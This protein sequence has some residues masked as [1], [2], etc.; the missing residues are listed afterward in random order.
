MARNELWAQK[1]LVDSA[2]EYNG[3]GEKLSHR[4]KVG[5]P[6][7]LIKLQGRH[8]FIVEAKMREAPVRYLGMEWDSWNEVTVLQRKNLQSWWDAGLQSGVV[9][10]CRLPKNELLVNFY[11]WPT[12]ATA[13]G[14]VR[15]EDF[16]RL[17]RTDK[18]AHLY[19]IMMEFARVL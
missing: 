8:P 1:L 3:Y 18:A 19:Q 10:F 6:D 4:F 2:I 14:V 9:L 12:Y 7:L 13:R 17:P 5:I 15:Y 11:E 16:H